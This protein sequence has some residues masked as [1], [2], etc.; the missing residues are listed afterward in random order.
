MVVANIQ[1][2]DASEALELADGPT[3]TALIE[4]LYAASKVLAV[5]S[6][7]RLASIHSHMQILIITALQ[8]QHGTCGARCMANSAAAVDSDFCRAQRPNR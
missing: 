3:V 4:S 6:D 1:L 7:F 5:D 8:S 2:H